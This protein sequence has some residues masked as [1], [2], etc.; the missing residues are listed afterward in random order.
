MSALHGGL[1]DVLAHQREEEHE[2]AL[3]AI[4]MH[5]LLLAGSPEFALVRRH[6]RYLREWLTR[7][8]GWSLQVER[9][10]ARLYKRPADAADATR[11]IEQYDRERY[12]LL[13]LACAVLERAEGQI[14]LRALGERLLEAAADPLLAEHGFSCTLATVRERRNLVQVC[15][16]LLSLGVLV[17]VAGDEEGYVNQSGTAD[18][19]YDVHRRVLAALPAST[20][21][22]SLIAATHP[23]LQFDGFLAA[24]L[25]EYVVDS[26][27]GHR[28][29]VRHRLARRLLDDPVVYLDE[30]APEEH[31][32]FMNQRGPMAARLAQA[33]GLVA[34]SRAEGVA[35]VDPQSELS[36]EFM[37]ATGTEAHITLLVA[38]HLGAA[39]E[40]GDRLYSLRELATFISGAA[41]RYGRYWR[42]SAREPGAELALAEQAVERLAAL[43]L[44][45]RLE[46]GIQT[47]PALLRYSVGE[48]QLPEPHTDQDLLAQHP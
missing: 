3:R 43:R 1:A 5:P 32:Y 8:T 35:L 14:T 25:E 39:R 47:R 41:N 24:L 45:R 15:R 9:E 30:L 29:A 46:E 27:D 20:R 2:R 28:M 31:D 42:K 36:D 22:A 37:P 33:T 26:P 38:E 12:V 23:E 16:L 17:R 7:E 21:G 13:C 18:V 4:L 6:A 44:V 48:A 40:Q 19:L 11:G 34:E 10:C